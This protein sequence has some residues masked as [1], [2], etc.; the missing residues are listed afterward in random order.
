MRLPFLLFK[1]IMDDWSFAVDKSAFNFS[2]ASGFIFAS[3]R[4]RL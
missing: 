1:I 3:T 2:L 4:L